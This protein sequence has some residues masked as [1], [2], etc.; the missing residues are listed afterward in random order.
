MEGPSLFLAQEQLVVFKGKKVKVVSGNTKIQK[1]RFL[2]KTVIDIFSWGKHLVFQFDTF[3]FR[4][5]FMLFGTYE[6]KVNNTWVT[7]DYKKAREPRLAL[8]F[9][10][11]CI[12]MYNCSIKIIEEKNIKSLYDFS[13]DIM[14]SK[15]D[16]K[17]AFKKIKDFP[18]EEIADVLLDQEIFSGVGNII[19]NEV[20]SQI[21]INPKTKIKNISQEILQK[22]IQET[23]LFSKQ[24]YEWRKQF[25][26]R[27]NLKIHRRSLCPHCNQKIIREKTGKKQRWS[28]YCPFCQ[29]E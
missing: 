22:L 5:H 28:Y 9:N 17:K 20:L 21:K 7:G 18:Q 3:G 2:N 8:T 12:N 26:L 23:Q 1:E 13:T 14:S 11:G 25:V 29:K 19:K 4:V 16:S 27:K 6:A 10:N 24:F 15:W